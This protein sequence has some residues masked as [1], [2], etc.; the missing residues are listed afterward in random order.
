M[1]ILTSEVAESP[2][3]MFCEAVDE[4]IGVKLKEPIVIGPGEQSLAGLGRDK[5]K[6]AMAENA[7]VR[8]NLAIRDRN[9]GR[10]KRRD[11]NEENVSDDEAE[12]LDNSEDSKRNRC[13]DNLER[14][15]EETT[16]AVKQMAHEIA[17]KGEEA[18][19]KEI[20]NLEPTMENKQAYLNA[21]KKA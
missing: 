3:E 21:L 15:G 14:Q 5:R 1:F 20:Y 16:K 9:C 10:Q 13:L 8:A 17:R 12:E 6:R 2:V 19:L 4:A 18:R 7:R 11:D